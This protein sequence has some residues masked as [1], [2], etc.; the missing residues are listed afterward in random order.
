MKN[1]II[2]SIFVLLLLGL[3]GTATA[4]TE[5]RPTVVVDYTIDPAVLMS[6]DTGTITMDIEN[7]ATGTVYVTEDDETFDMNAYIASITLAGN[8]NIDVIS[9]GYTDIGLL[10][11][12]DTIKLTFNVRAKDNATNGI[13]FLNMEVVGGSDM[14]DL[15]YNI[16]VK[17][18][19]RDLKLIMATMPSTV[20]NEIST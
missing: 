5:I 6:G 19:N 17:I 10:G 3:T 7:M 4:E 20:M 14:Y 1:K 15:N 12:K 18:D 11:P 2:V 8:S 13:H 9:K 16:P